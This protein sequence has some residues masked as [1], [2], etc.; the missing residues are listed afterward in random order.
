MNLS[1]AVMVNGIGV[2]VAEGV[3]TAVGVMDVTISVVAGLG[4]LSAELGGSDVPIVR[5]DLDRP[6]LDDIARLT[7]YSSDVHSA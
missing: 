2:G 4:R 5:P 1:L 3:A 6:D 7:A